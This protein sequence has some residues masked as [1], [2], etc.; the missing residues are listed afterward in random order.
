MAEYDAQLADKL[1]IAE[2]KQRAKKNAQPVQPASRLQGFGPAAP[3]VAPMRPVGDIMRAAEQ[4]RSM[5]PAPVA[6]APAPTPQAAPAPQPQMGPANPI[7]ANGRRTLADIEFQRRQVMQGFRNL[8]PEWGQTP[9]AAAERMRL[10]EMRHQLDTQGRALSGV[11]NPP[12]PVPTTPEEIARKQ[13]QVAASQAQLQAQ[14]AKNVGQYGN[15]PSARDQ[16]PIDYAARAKMADLGITDMAQFQ[17]MQGLATPVTPDRVAASEVGMD[18]PTQTWDT[19]KLREQQMMGTAGAAMGPQAQPTLNLAPYDP[20]AAQAAADRY[21]ASR[22]GDQTVAQNAVGDFLNAE[23][24]RRNEQERLRQLA[25]AQ[26]QSAIY[27]SQAEGNLARAAGSPDY[28]DAML[29]ARIAEANA[30]GLG[31]ET[32]NIQAQTE[33]AVAKQGLTDTTNRLANRDDQADQII[34]SVI[35]A[36]Q[37]LMRSAG[38]DSTDAP[39][40]AGIGSGIQQLLDQSRTWDQAKADRYRTVIKQQLGV[41]SPSDLAFSSWRNSV[42]KFLSNLPTSSAARLQTVRNYEAAKVAMMQLR[43]FLFPG[44]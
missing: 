20:A 40:I 35:P 25:E 2:I 39:V 18:R 14:F 12:A 19:L 34:T 28:A 27:Q 21:Q 8:G 11:L 1:M 4:A 44:G 3:G 15:Q 26:Q 38:V 33:N 13:A 37:S 30:A 5:A 24:F 43:A 36:V 31:A 16:A 6:P 7:D 23:T 32:K 10:A 22:Q 29:R 17:R 42:D 41:T 9:Q